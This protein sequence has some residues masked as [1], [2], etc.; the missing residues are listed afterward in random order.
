LSYAPRAKSILSRSIFYVN[1]GKH[2]L[3]KNVL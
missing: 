1:K 2:F 3:L